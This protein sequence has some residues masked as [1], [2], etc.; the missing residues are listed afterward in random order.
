MK[1]E[2][3]HSANQPD[4]SIRE[5]EDKMTNEAEARVTETEL[6]HLEGAVGGLQVTPRATAS[7]LHSMHMIAE[8][9]VAL[10]QCIWSFYK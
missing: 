1:K 5:P 2:K 3:E 4:S 8:Y 9:F 6:Q 10:K 7:K